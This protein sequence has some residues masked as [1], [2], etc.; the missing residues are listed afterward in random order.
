MTQKCLCS[1][2]QTLP[3]VLENREGSCSQAPDRLVTDK[4]ILWLWELNWQVL[5]RGKGEGRRDCVPK[6]QGWCCCVFEKESF[7]PSCKRNLCQCTIWCNMFTSCATGCD[8]C[9]DDTVYCTISWS[10]TVDCLN[11]LILLG[12]WC[13]QQRNGECNPIQ[14]SFLNPLLIQRKGEGAK[15]FRILREVNLAIHFHS[16]NANP[17]S[18]YYL[19]DADLFETGHKRNQSVHGNGDVDLPHTHKGRQTVCLKDARACPIAWMW[20]KHCS[21]SP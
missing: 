14:V 9:C 21:K 13:P 7:P 5:P 2:T 20:Q 4:D 1:Q 19:Q 12:I 18:M 17:S 16:S 10:S 15:C 3:T 8:T 11:L 6:W